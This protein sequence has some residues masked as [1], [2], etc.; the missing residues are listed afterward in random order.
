[1]I[2]KL[3]QEVKRPPPSSTLLPSPPVETGYLLLADI[4]GYTLFMVKTELEHAQAVIKEIN[5]VIIDSLT[6]TMA[7]AEVEGDAVFV[8]APVSG[9]SHG[10]DVVKLIEKTYVRFRRKR[11]EMSSMA[12]CPCRAC[13]AIPSLDLKFILHVGK[14]VLQTY[15]HQQKPVGSD[16]NLSHRL[17]KNGVGAS[18]GWSAYVLFT[19]QGLEMMGI[20][21]HGLFTSVE[22]Y[23]HFPPLR[24]Y[25]LNL[26]TRAKEISESRR[27]LFKDRVFSTGH[28]PRRFKVDP[29]VFT[30]PVGSNKPQERKSR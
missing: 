22:R 15:G 24:T 29:Q 5:E 28:A 27:Y 10:D 8:H 14:Y 26:E 6:P 11:E 4:T 18:T 21:P 1:M 7:L 13:K 25:S 20:R 16:V 12:T 9:I 30:L 3:I 19:Q 23:E 2:D 17:L